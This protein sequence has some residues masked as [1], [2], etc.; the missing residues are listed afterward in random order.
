M[1]WVSKI[2]KIPYSYLIFV[3][4]LLF[5]LGAMSNQ[6]VLIANWGKFPV[7]LNEREIREMQQPV[8]RNIW[9]S[10]LGGNDF[11]ALDTVVVI[12]DTQLD[13]QSQFLDDVHSIMGHNS[14]LKWLADYLSIGN[15]IFSPGDLF[16]ML[17]EYLMSFSF[18]MWLG[19]ILRKLIIY[20][21]A[22]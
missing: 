12:P 5:L 21:Q 16:L 13:E 2:P 3:P 6:A 4:V 7:M 15:D 10:I 8:D 22:G 19:L 17:S 11:S 14:R 9:K 18:P 1:K 20:E